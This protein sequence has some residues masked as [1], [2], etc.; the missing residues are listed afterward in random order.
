MPL[1]QFY[2]A[3]GEAPHPPPQPCA[4]NKRS[5][6]ICHLHL[7]PPKEYQLRQV[8]SVRCKHATAKNRLVSQEELLAM[9][10][11]YLTSRYQ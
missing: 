6:G 2:F 4:Y 10:V 5:H 11:S 1:L 7:Y 9:L 8:L 3:P